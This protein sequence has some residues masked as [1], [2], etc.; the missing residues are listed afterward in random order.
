MLGL[1]DFGNI[2]RP[3]LIAVFLRDFVILYIYDISD[4]FSS[5]FTGSIMQNI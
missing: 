3:R 5:R 2:Y 1:D 4:S